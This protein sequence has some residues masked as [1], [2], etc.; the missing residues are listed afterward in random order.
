[1]SYTFTIGNA[2]PEF[3]KDDGYL[4]ARWVVEDAKL[5][6][7]PQF[8]NDG[9]TGQTNSRSPAYS[10]WADFCRSAGIY[11]VFYDERGRLHAGHPGCELLTQD[12]YTRI[13]VALEIYQ[14]NA[15]LPPGFSDWDGKDEGKYDSTLARLLW[16][17][18]WMRW[19]LANCETPAIQNT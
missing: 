11:D 13:K 18:F 19:A 8:P 9:M 16:L 7:A 12:Q 17:E 10:A 5:D 6:E 3:S 1:M 4:S 15:T 14:R 2:V